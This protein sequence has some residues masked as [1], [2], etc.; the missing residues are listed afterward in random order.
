MKLYSTC[1]LN[2]LN[3]VGVNKLVVVYSLVL[4]SLICYS[5]KIDTLIW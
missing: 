1:I 4:L 5:F 3:E 2:V